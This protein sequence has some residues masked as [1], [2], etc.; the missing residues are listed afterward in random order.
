MIH[1][2]RKIKN[3]TVHWLLKENIK[4]KC[5]AH[6]TMHFYC[7]TICF[8][9][10][11]NAKYSTFLCWVQDQGSQ[12]SSSVFTYCR[13]WQKQI[14]HKITTNV[15]CKNMYANKCLPW[16]FLLSELTFSSCS[17]CT[18]GLNASLFERGKKT[19]KCIFHVCPV[20]S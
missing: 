10:H 6:F 4:W 17:F 12:N 14:Y 18:L 19:W 20:S 1:K 11:K 7:W 3:N 8:I 9:Q 15:N 13:S 16:T 2:K 5:T